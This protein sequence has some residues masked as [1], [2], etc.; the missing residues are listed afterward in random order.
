MSDED[1]LKAW[2]KIVCG[3]NG[4]VQVTCTIQDGNRSVKWT[5]Q[6]YAGK[7]NAKKAGRLAHK[8]ALEHLDALR[9]LEQ[10]IAEEAA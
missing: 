2:Y 3:A 8:Q 4:K 1:E 7:D 10:E 9:E 6:T 5:V